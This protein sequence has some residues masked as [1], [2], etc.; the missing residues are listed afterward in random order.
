MDATVLGAWVATGLTL[1]IFSFLYKDNPLFNSVVP[2]INKLNYIKITSHYFLCETYW[3][4]VVKAT[5]NK[6]PM[7]TAKKFKHSQNSITR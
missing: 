1:F 5:I 2:T 7:R 4:I 6:R 3:K